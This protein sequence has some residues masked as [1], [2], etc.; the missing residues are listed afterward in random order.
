M[1]Y[2]QITYDLRTGTQNGPAYLT[3]NPQGLVPTLEED[4]EVLTQS[5][6]IV[7]YIAE[8]FP[9]LPIWPRDRAGAPA[10]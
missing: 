9:H 2:E 8:L 3:V 1:T 7:E 6:A 10:P 4:G 5:L